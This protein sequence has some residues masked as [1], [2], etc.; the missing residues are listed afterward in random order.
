MLTSVTDVYDRGIGEQLPCGEYECEKD[1][2]ERFG[3][4]RDWTPEQATK[5]WNAA[6][7]KA[8]EGK[9]EDLGHAGFIQCPCCKAVMK[10]VLLNDYLEHLM[11]ADK[12]EIRQ[13]LLGTPVRIFLKNGQ[14]IEMRG[15]TVKLITH[16]QIQ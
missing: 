15:K 16:E 2:S 12:L 14:Q 4:D 9:E 8:L 10:L 6:I 3:L 1:E 11:L 7:A 5:L 13:V